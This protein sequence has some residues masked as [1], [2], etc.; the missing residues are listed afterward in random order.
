M[1]HFFYT[2]DFVNIFN[3]HITVKPIYFMFYA[4]NLK[5]RNLKLDY[6]IPQ[7]YSILNN[8]FI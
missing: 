5:Y 2:K 3:N 1:E 6:N 7:C 4:Q 8:N